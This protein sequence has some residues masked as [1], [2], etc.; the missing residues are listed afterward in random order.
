MTQICYLLLCHK[1][2]AAVIDQVNMLTGQGDCVVIHIDRS[3]PSE[4]G[5]QIRS[6]LA[7]MADVRFAKSVKCGWG[8]WSLV[9]ASLNA[10]RLGEAEFPEATHFYL[11]SGDC[12]PIKSAG[13]VHAHLETNDQDIIEVHDFLDS[14]WIKV[15]MKEERLIYRHYFNERGQKRLFYSALELQKRLGLARDIPEGLRVMIGSQWF[16]LRRKTVEKILALVARRKD[17]IRFFR[18]TWIP[19]ETFF[20][21]LVYHL[22]PKAEIASHP[23]TFLLFSDYGMPVNF[24]NDHYDFLI[25][26]DRFFARKLSGQAV[27]LKT[28]LRTL[29]SDTEVAFGTARSGEQYFRYLTSRGRKGQRFAPRHWEAAAQLDNTLSVFVVA[30]KKWHVA[31]R[32]AQSLSEQ[33][34]IPGYGYIFNETEAGLPDLGNA[35]STVEKRQRQRCA[36]L[37]LLFDVTGQRRLI[38]CIDPANQEVLDDLKDQGAEIRVLEIACEFSDH[39]LHGHAERMGIEIATMDDAM[40]R[41]LLASLRGDIAE[42]SR[43]LKAM[44]LDLFERFGEHED[45]ETITSALCR[46]ADLDEDEAFR[47]AHQGRFNQL[48]SAHVQL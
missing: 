20:Q 19:D 16:C 15:G 29:Y 48:G 30:C 44:Q 18:T 5:Q 25:Q 8:E 33:S 11:I 9:K 12:M 36:F 2:P 17:L 28:R 26:Q 35:G 41:D 37:K 13:T 47:A 45:P 10:L 34:G 3:A 38:F 22:V 39:Y 31:K 7:G 40:I 14:G 6:G 21:S 4:V 32:Y 1:N 27:E 42:E 46:F 43:A 24:Q 23:P